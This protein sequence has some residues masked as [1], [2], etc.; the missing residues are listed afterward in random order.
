MKLYRTIEHVT[1]QITVPYREQITPHFCS[2]ARKTMRGL[3]VIKSISEIKH[4]PEAI[5]SKGKL[6]DLFSGSALLESGSGT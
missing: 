3:N 5:D 6:T 2:E 4:F 1:S